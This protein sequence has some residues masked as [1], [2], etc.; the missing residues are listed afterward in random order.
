MINNIGFMQG[1][2]SPIVDNKIQA[3]PFENW[4][5]EF[6]LAHKLNLSCIEWTLD[7]PNLKSNPL[8]QKKYHEEIVFTSKKNKIL[9][10]SITLDI[11]MQ[12]PFWKELNKEV[13]NNLITDL[14]LVINSASSIGAK[15]LIIPL[16]DNGS[17]KDQ[18][19]F[20]RLKETIISLY[21]LLDLRGIKIAFESDYSPCDLANFI[22][23]FEEKYIG[24][25]YDI[26][27][28]ASLG[29][30]PDE[31][32]NNYGDR[33]IN[34][35]VKDR[36]LNGGT[37]RLGNGAVNFRNVFN[38]LKKIK[39]KGNYILQTARSSRNLHFEELKIN[40]SFLQNF[41]N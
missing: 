39:Y 41:L 10:N 35:H 22:K 3:F 38:N 18:N 11:C 30:N 19:Q 32:F 4:S 9:I 20:F 23:D 27:N 7:Y 17:I 14:K 24:I 15:I 36:L 2:L 25:N 1:R 12:R 5:D 16:V 37:V 21:E 6:P 40:L 34:V 28:S 8:L 31:E 26:G 13:F 33:I 29:F